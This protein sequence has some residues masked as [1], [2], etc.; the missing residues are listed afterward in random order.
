MI[1][2]PWISKCDLCKKPKPENE[3]WGSWDGWL[4]FSFCPDC[5]KNR[6]DECMNVMFEAESER[7]RRAREYWNTHPEELA[8]HQRET[9]EYRKTLDVD[10]YPFGC[11]RPWWKYI[12]N[13]IYRKIGYTKFDRNGIDTRRVID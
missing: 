4:S 6:E 13:W 7:I 12:R 1:K 3:S 2:E 11:Q 9:A 5:E 8:K 10:G